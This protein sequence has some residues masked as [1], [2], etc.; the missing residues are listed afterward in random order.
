M[1][2]QI[3]SFCHFMTYFGHHPLPDSSTFAAVWSAYEAWSKEQ[4]SLILQY[5]EEIAEIAL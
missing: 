4:V 2:K 1:P 3:M 5:N